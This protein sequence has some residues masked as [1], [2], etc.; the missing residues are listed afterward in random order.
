M[1]STM[2]PWTAFW[3]GAGLVAGVAMLFDWWDNR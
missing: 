1:Y 2:D 3:I